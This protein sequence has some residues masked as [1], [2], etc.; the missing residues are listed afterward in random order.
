MGSLAQAGRPWAK[1]QRGLR[2]PWSCLRSALEEGMRRG[3]GG[4]DGG[5]ETED[6]HNGACG[7]LG[8]LWSSLCTDGRTEHSG[9]T[10]SRS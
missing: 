4:Q 7:G 9:F 1:F 5:L 6:P 8:S 10:P 3:L 2:S